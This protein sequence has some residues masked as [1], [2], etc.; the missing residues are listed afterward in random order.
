M[1]KQV[2]VVQKTRTNPFTALRGGVVLVLVLACALTVIHLAATG[3]AA[4][5]L[6]YAPGWS[7]ESRMTVGYVA[8]PFLLAMTLM[9]MDRQTRSSMR[10]AS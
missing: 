8:V 5:L 4:I 6:Q 7:W 3:L 2:S 1:S 9:W 10:L